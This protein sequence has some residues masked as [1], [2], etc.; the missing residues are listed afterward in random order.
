MLQSAC[1]NP[2][3]IPF[4][5]QGWHLVQATLNCV[6][7]PKVELERGPSPSLPTFSCK[8]TK[9]CSGLDSAVSQA[10][11]SLLGTI[12][13]H[14]GVPRM[15][16]FFCGLHAGSVHGKTFWGC[17]HVGEALPV[18]L[19][20]VKVCGHLFPLSGLKCSDL[21]GGTNSTF[22]FCTAGVPAHILS[23]ATAPSP[24]FG[25]ISTCIYSSSVMPRGK[26]AVG[27]GA[28][29]TNNF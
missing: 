20:N 25:I 9:L 14:S 8:K 10:W 28:V 24:D 13:C 18:S 4:P 16:M 12:S 7:A 3:G 22:L 5:L 21:C 23:Q 29:F 19:D 6:D 26:N 2:M 17:R 27:A 11:T 15:K 1:T